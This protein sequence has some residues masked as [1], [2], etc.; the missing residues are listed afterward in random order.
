LRDITE[1]NE[2]VEMEKKFWRRGWDS[3]FV[4]RIQRQTIIFTWPCKW[5]GKKNKD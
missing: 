5:C 2:G 1:K 4:N 3:D